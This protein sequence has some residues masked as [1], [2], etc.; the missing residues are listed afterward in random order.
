MAERVPTGVSG[1]SWVWSPL[2][3]RLWELVVR[4]PEEDLSAV[5]GVLRAL[6][7]SLGPTEDHW[8]ASLALTQSPVPDMG[9]GAF[10]V[11]TLETLLSL[12]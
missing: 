4:A 7:L 10:G 3:G 9:L 1:G 5:E 12:G 11:G 6:S 8:R 2:L